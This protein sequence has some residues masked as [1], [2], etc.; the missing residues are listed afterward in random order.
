M[1]SR[2][3]LAQSDHGVIRRMRDIR[4]TVQKFTLP[5]PHII[6]LPSLTLLWLY[7]RLFSVLHYLWRL[8][9]CEPVLKAR[10]KAFGKG[11]RTDIY[12]HSIQGRGDLILGDDV[13]MDGRC[14]VKFAARFCESPTLSIGD[15]TGI[16]HACSFT[17]GKRISIGRHCRIASN[18]FM[19]DASGHPVDPEARRAGLPPGD[20]D[21]KPITVEDNV[22]IGRWAI[23]YPGVTIGEGSVVAAGS[24]VTSDVPPYTVVAGNPA[25]RLMALQAPAPGADPEERLLAAPR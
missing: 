14:S 2:R 19:F 5:A 6:A 20:E 3:R 25:R 10:C 7:A 24:V 22:W 12:L 8:F 16:G 17:I 11:V 23:L 21:V 1:L 13:L 18:V 9:V 15:H 4:R